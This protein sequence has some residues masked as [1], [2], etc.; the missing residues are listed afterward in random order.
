M[1]FEQVLSALYRNR[2]AYAEAVNFVY[3]TLATVYEIT[4]SSELGSTAEHL[5]LATLMLE[6]PEEGGVSVV[7]FNYDMAVED[8]ICGLSRLAAGQLPAGCLFFRYGFRQRVL[9]AVPPETMNLATTP[10][11]YPDGRVT[12]LKLHGSINLLSCPSCDALAYFPFQVL[13]H[14]PAD[15]LKAS[16]PCCHRGGPPEPLIVPP[17]ERKELPP[18]LEELWQAAESMLE[19]SSVVVIAGYSMP[20]YDKEARRFLRQ[21]LQCKQVILVDPQPSEDA[22]G[23]LRKIP[24]VQVDVLAM[25]ATAFL[26]NEVNR[27]NPRLLPKLAPDCAPVYLDRHLMQDLPRA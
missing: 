9:S 27:Y 23:F 7:T 19:S 4:Q 15:Y 5:G 1:N 10:N 25:T 6:H 8:A 3:R 14:G 17:G 13:T 2:A 16:C 26:R 18:A 12:V 20:E 21:T 11:T 22:I 24:G